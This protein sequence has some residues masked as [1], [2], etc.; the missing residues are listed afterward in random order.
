VWFV[1]IVAIDAGHRAFRYSMMKR[2]LKLSITLVWQ[3]AHW[4]LI[5]RR[6]A[7][8]QPKRTVG[9]NFMARRASHLIPR[10]AALQAAGV[11]RLAEVASQA[12]LV[13]SGSSELPRIANVFGRNGLGVL[14]AGAVTRFAGFPCHPRLA[15]ASTARCGFRRGKR[16][17]CPQTRPARFGTRIRGG[18][19][20]DGSLARGIRGSH[21]KKR[22]RQRDVNIEHAFCPTEKASSAAV[23]NGATLSEGR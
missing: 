13:G 23:A 15:S 6:F 1:G 7:R 21:N 4:S 8:H 12:D 11:R 3:A 22:R 9:V 2:F 17:R 18:R 14:L 10:M 16:W 19:S 5:R 20:G